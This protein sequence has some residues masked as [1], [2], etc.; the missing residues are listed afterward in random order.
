MRRKFET[1]LILGASPLGG[2]IA[3]LAALRGSTVLLCDDSQDAVTE[4]L[5]VIRERFDRSVKKRKL[6]A[7][8]RDEALGRILRVDDAA[9]GDEVDLA[10]EAVEDELK[11]KRRAVKTLEKTAGEN[12]LLATTTSLLSVSDVAEA[13]EDP[14]R[15]VGL[16]FFHPA[17]NTRLVEIVAGRETGKN[18]VTR[19][20]ELV[21]AWGK[22]PVRVNDGPG[23]I[24]RRIEAIFF[25]EA[26]RLLD[27][28]VAGMDEIDGILRKHG[29]LKGGPFEHMDALGLDTV[30]A[31]LESIHQRSGGKG[32]FEPHPVLR[33]LVR[34][35]QTGRPSGAGF[36]D[37]RFKH[38]V[39]A[40]TV[41]RKSFQLDP[42]LADALLSFTRKGGAPQTTS[43]EQY[44]FARILAAVIN[45][46]GFVYAEDVA[47]SG[48]VD[49]AMVEGSVFP[50]GPLAW[51][52]VIG[53]NTTAGVLK[54]LNG[55]VDDNRFE[56]CPLFA[57]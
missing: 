20:V 54:A 18:H 25:L 43:T 5:S 35:G 57:R 2:G 45:E 6:K 41:D 33:K 1:V 23:F 49:V 28:G 9:Q 46:A 4:A 52:D 31:L 17:P 48:D 13:A 34:A 55:N 19:A 30:L 39:P 8:E 14:A 29:H 26:M 27:E 37:Y 51:A 24:V 44:V 12:A 36:Y 7:K 22:A 50:R 56:A 16:H 32:R 53:H 3:E 38:P 21:S 11:A 40:L 15:V 47:T 42:L 10:I